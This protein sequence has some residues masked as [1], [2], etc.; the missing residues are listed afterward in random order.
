MRYAGVP[1]RRVGYIPLPRAICDMP[2]G[3]WVD[4]VVWQSQGVTHISRSV[5]RM[6]GA[7]PVVVPPLVGEATLMRRGFFFTT[8]DPIRYEQVA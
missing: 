6:C 5:F 4:P 2:P 3:R 1:A 8:D 7:R